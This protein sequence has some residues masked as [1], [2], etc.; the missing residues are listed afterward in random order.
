MSAERYDDVENH[1]DQNELIKG[2][3]TESGRLGIGLAG[4]SGAIDVLSDAIA[5]QADL[6]AK[7]AQTAEEVSHNNEQVKNNAEETR[8]AVGNAREKV[9]HGRGVFDDAQNDINK[10]LT[11]VLDIAQRLE[12]FGEALENVGRVAETIDGIAKQTN[13]LA[14]NATIEAARAGGAGKG[15][16][17]VAGEVKALAGETSSATAD[18]QEILSELNALGTGAIQEIAQARDH[19]QH[20]A[21]QSSTLSHT[22]GDVD[23]A[24]AT[25][26]QKASEIAQAT[27]Q[28]S[29]SA[30]EV[31]DATENLSTKA[32]ESNSALSQSRDEL[33]DLVGASERL[34]ALS[35]D[36]GVETVDTPFV[37]RALDA[38][39][40]IGK[41]FEEEIAS[42]RATMDDFFDKNYQPVPGSNPAQVTTRFT[43]ITDRLLP[44]LQEDI[45]GMDPSVVFCAAV[46][47]SGYLPTHN[48]KFSQPQGDDPDWNSAHC[49][50]RRIFDDRVG[51]SAGQNTKPFLL[52]TYRRDMG[53]GQFALMKDLSAPIMINGRHWGGFR[54]AYKI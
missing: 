2:V 22:L 37:R 43:T 29:K 9:S 4:V 24:I 47:T 28:I 51:L 16:A 20:V 6:C 40:Q 33:H 41:M 5:E 10:L 42:G 23:D 27:E 1:H 44:D 30:H 46:D 3:A 52:Q 18:I 54:L 36:A 26:D 38:A 8:S 17:V 14:L 32:K 31:A 39:A 49:R 45:L 35:A 11:Q 34:I 50:N 12:G 21:E 15:F 25:I 53:G 13:L 7:L 19:A 48:K